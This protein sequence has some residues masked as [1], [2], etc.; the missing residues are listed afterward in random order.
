MGMAV[1]MHHSK[2]KEGEEKLERMERGERQDTMHAMRAVNG[3]INGETAQMKVHTMC[4]SNG[5]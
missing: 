4:T 1:E 2:E 5:G 3:G